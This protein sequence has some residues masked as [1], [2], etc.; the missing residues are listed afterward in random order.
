MWGDKTAHP[1]WHFPAGRRPVESRLALLPPP[2]LPPSPLSL[3]WRALEDPTWHL[4]LPY[5]YYGVGI[6]PQEAHGPQPSSDKPTTQNIPAHLP[7][8]TKNPPTPRLSCMRA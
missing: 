6:H 1:S 7:P 8:L 2:F 5:T 3:P 4:P